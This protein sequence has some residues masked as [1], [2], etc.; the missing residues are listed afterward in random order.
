MKR[1]TFL[2]IAGLLMV[3]GVAAAALHLELTG[4][5]R[6]DI[7]PDGSTWHELAPAFCTTHTQDGYED[8]GDGHISPCDFIR[9]G[10]SRYHVTWVGPTYWLIDHATGEEWYAEPTIPDP[11][12]DPF[13]EIWVEVHPNLG[14]EWHVDGWEDNGDGV[15]SPCDNVLIRGIWYHIHEIGLNITVEPSSPVEQTTWAKV[16]AF[17]ARLF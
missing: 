12:Q 11:G 1:C 7:P 13:C 9:F 17:F 3:S 4:P 16:K 2:L 6:Q 15:V 14:D 10:G 8:N 5:V